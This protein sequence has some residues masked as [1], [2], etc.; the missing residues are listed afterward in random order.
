MVAAM[1]LDMEIRA[2]DAMLPSLRQDRG[3]VW[4]VV[5]GSELKGTF[6]DFQEAAQ[7]A[8]ENLGDLDYLI[9]H[10]HEHTAH[11]PFIAVDA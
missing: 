4:A 3:S 6:E 10:T 11:I 9:R 5:V 7:Y 1:L 2:F 8:I